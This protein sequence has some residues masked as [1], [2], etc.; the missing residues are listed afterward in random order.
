M[1]NLEL[2]NILRYLYEEAIAEIAREEPAKGNNLGERLYWGSFSIFC[3]GF[4]HGMKL[5]A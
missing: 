4:Y 1:D 5:S 2:E 3:A